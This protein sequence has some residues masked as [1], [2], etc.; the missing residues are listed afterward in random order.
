MSGIRTLFQHR[1][2]LIALLLVLTLGVRALIPTGYM[3]NSSARGLTIELCSGVAGKTVTLNLPGL[4]KTGH[5]GKVSMDMP[6]AFSGVG[7]DS[8]S[9]IDPIILAIA[10]AFTMALGF[11]AVASRRNDAPAYLRPPLRGPPAA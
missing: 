7:F 5:E 9:S 2:G 3:A 6:C 11:R 4:Q 1:A 10:V 8:A